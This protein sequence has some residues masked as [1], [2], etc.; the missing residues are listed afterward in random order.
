MNEMINEMYQQ[1]CREIFQS[2]QKAGG[3]IDAV[4]RELL[5]VMERMRRNVKQLETDLQVHLSP[6]TKSLFHICWNSEWDIPTV[7]DLRQETEKAVQGLPVTAATE[8]IALWGCKNECKTCLLKAKELDLLANNYQSVWICPLCTFENTK[9]KDICQMC[10][11]GKSQPRLVL[12]KPL[13]KR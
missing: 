13:S 6:Q 9:G 2:Y 10:Y 3:E 12:T 7:L 5:E 1:N 4:Y 11:F 8:V